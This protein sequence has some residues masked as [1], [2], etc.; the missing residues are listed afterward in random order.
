M[1]MFISYPGSEIP[2]SVGTNCSNQAGTNYLRLQT[3]KSGNLPTKSF[4]TLA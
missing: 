1:S 3:A 2:F 4:W